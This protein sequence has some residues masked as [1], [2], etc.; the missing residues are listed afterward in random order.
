MINAINFQKQINFPKTDTTTNIPYINISNSKSDSSNLQIES[1]HLS[2]K[3]TK[4]NQNPNN[5]NQIKNQNPNNNNNILTSTSGFLSLNSHIITGNISGTQFSFDNT[6]WNESNTKFPISSNSKIKNDVSP[7]TKNSI[8][9]SPSIVCNYY[10]HSNDVTPN[11]NINNDYK[12]IN[13]DFSSNKGKLKQINLNNK[14]IKND[15]N[16]HSDDND[17]SV[18]SDNVCSSRRKFILEKKTPI[19]YTKNQLKSGE[20]NRSGKS[21]NSNNSKI[22]SS[23]VI[24]I[25]TINDKTF[26]NINSNSRSENS[27]NNEN[28]NQINNRN[29]GRKNLMDTFDK[30][31]K[32]KEIN[33]NNNGNNCY[34]RQITEINLSEWDKKVKNEKKEIHNK[35]NTENF[36]DKVENDS[37]FMNTTS[38]QQ[39]NKSNNSGN[40]NENDNSSTIIHKKND[41]KYSTIIDIKSNEKNIDFNKEIISKAIKRKNENKKKNDNFS[42]D[43]SKTIIKEIKRTSEKKKEN[44]F[45]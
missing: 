26:N 34:S 5:N 12:I 1:S 7:I 20:K 9:Y 13:D 23:P 8:L 29:G 24:N 15:I 32:E 30:I 43:I 2:L 28:N 42:F 39:Q 44:C 4:L 21:Y 33:Y 31:S 37:S 38:K 27:K 41:D 19:K 22:D 45:I 17:N 11:K 35:R 40:T 10:Q 3:S 16:S 14:N 6:S 36:F 18:I 25:S